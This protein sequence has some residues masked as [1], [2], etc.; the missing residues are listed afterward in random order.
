MKIRL[1]FVSNSSSSSFFINGRKED[2]V[3]IKIPLSALIRELQDHTD[4][5]DDIIV[6][7]DS[8]GRI[9][10]KGYFKYSGDGPC[11]LEKLIANL[12]SDKDNHPF[13]KLLKESNIDCEESGY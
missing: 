4:R 11:Q 13:E 5:S 6:K 12:Y 2:I 3:N 10:V 8:D 7:E 1:G 9:L